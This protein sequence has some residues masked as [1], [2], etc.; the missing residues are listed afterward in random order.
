M[1]TYDYLCE[2]CG[3]F[4]A[5]RPML[6]YAEPAN[7]PGCGQSARRAMLTVPSIA[8]MSTG[9]RKAHATNERSANAPRLSSAGAH[10]SGCK[11]CSPARAK[12]PAMA[13]S[14]PAARPWMISH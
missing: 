7:C 2:D 6:E 4:T 10:R 5:L 14:F 8:M 9:Q 3:S 12:A 1:P 11:C 13:K